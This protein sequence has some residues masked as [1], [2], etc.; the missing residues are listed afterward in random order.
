MDPAEA[1]Q[2]P[3]DEKKGD[4]PEHINI[5]VVSDDNS[6][7]FFKIKRTTPFRK[8]MDAYCQRQGKSLT[9]VRFLYDGE[10]ISPD[11]TPE[12]LEMEDEDTIDVMIEQ[13]GGRVAG[14]EKVLTLAS[15]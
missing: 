12:Q 8:L 9:T 5:K 15:M 13:I 1:N 10:R 14:L 3:T 7:V 2:S 4:N 6:E 11:Q